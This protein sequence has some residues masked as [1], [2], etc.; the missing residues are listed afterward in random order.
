MNKVFYCKNFFGL[1]MIMRMCGLC[2]TLKCKK[3][4]ASRRLRVTKVIVINTAPPFVI[5][6]KKSLLDVCVIYKGGYENII[7]DF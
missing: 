3:K 4:V 6:S 1:T 7:S 2:K 5:A